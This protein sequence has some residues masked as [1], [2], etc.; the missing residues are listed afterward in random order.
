MPFC[1]CLFACLFSELSVC[2][3]ACLCCAWVFMFVHVVGFVL[4]A[5][6][7]PGRLAAAR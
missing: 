4:L 1:V 3:L 6:L 7:G 5:V 2:L